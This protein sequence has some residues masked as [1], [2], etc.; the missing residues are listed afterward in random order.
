M[1][2]RWFHGQILTRSTF[3][4]WR[5]LPPPQYIVAIQTLTGWCDDTVN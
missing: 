1:L 2:I 3:D 4:F 5:S